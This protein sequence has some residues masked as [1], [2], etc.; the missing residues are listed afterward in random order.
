[1]I[2]EINGFKMHF[3]DEGDGSPVLLIHGFPL[4]NKMWSPQIKALTRAGFRVIAPDLRGF[5]G[6][7]AGYAP[8]S[9]DLLSDDIIAL[10][11]HLEIEKAVIGG[12]SM[13]GYILLNLLDRYMDRISAAVFIVTRS[14]ADDGPGKERRTAL[15]D[16]A[17][18]GR[19][20]VVAEAFES[21]LFGPHVKEDNPKLICKVRQ[22]M[23]MTSPEALSEGLRGMRDRP[24]YRPDLGRF[25]IPALVIGGEKDICISPEFSKDIAAGLPDSRLHIMEGVGH[26][27]NMEAPDRFNDC[28]LSFLSDS[29]PLAK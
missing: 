8:F 17:M 27:A 21:V 26:M 6:S 10:M 23:D 24:D 22:W 7:D 18:S 1:M 28:L 20:S 29:P 13:G 15:A 16:A 5:G 12:M 25:N 4:C 2:S 14:A 11:D 9:I 3:T 19:Q